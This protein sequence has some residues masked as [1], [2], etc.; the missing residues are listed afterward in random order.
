MSAISLLCEG[1]AVPAPQDF[2][3]RSRVGRST[4]SARWICAAGSNRGSGAA[5]QVIED[6]ASYPPARL[7]AHVW[8]KW[9]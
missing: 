8:N 2:L 6:W 3:T 1:R 9:P 4:P 5:R 7:Q